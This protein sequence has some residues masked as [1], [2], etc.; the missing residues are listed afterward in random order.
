MGVSVSVSSDSGEVTVKYASI[1]WK[2]SL[3][4]TFSALVTILLSK[5]SLRLQ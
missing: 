1:F 4:V 2:Y 3:S 5:G